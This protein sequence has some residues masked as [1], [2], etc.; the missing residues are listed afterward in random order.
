M[1]TAEAAD[2]VDE[3]R[4]SIRGNPSQFHIQI[5]VTGQ[6]VVSHGGTA[7]RVSATGGAAGSTTIG[8]Q[9]LVGGSPV[10][11][12]QQRGQQAMDAQMQALQEVLSALSAQLRASQPDKS[13]VKDLYEQLKDTWVPGVITSVVGS[14]VAKT[15]G[16]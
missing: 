13:V 16:F 12:A 3:I 8:Q 4:S 6:S 15:I 2:L 7:L 10:V 11:I 14:V 1:N 9:V 5:N